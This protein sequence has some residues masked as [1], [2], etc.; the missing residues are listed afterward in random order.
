MK[1]S[2]RLLNLLKASGK[3]YVSGEAISKDLGITRAAVW[4]E[5]QAL[6][7]LGY[8]ISAL[9]H[10]G[11]RLLSVPD[12]LFADEI[13]YGLRTEKVGK[14]IFSYETLD[15][16]NSVAARLGDEGLPEGVCV[17]AEYQKKGRGRLGRTWSSPKGQGILF[18]V[19]LRPELAPSEVSRLTLMAAVAVIRA[20]EG[21]TG[22]KP[23]VKWPNDVVHEGKKLCGILTEM[24]G[25]IDREFA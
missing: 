18:S 20:I 9:T 14:R 12:K 3:E 8:G 13:Q 6:K 2:D 19:L 4:K 16:T 15:S 25:E 17:F 1:H 22:L 10:R 23:A 24:S 11:Y 21:V 7:N 5:I